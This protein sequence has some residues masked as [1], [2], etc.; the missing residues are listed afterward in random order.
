MI[1]KMSLNLPLKQ[2][3]L[4][5]ANNSLVIIYSNFYSLLVLGLQ[6]QLCLQL[7][8][9]LQRSVSRKMHVKFDKYLLILKL[10]V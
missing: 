3:Y 4:I 1:H 6:E 10:T 5:I 8:Y 9:L 2:D 7:L